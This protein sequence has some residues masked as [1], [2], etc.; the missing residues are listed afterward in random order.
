VKAPRNLNELFFD[1]VDR[2]SSK[3]AAFQY[4][5]DG[6]WHD[7]THQE[8][9]QRV[10][11]TALGLLELGVRSG[12]RVGILSVNRPEW[13]IADYACL[14]VRCVDVPVYPTLPAKQ[15]AYI[16]RDSGAVALFVS[17]PSQYRK[18]EETRAEIPSLK[19][20]I[21]F[22]GTVQGPGVRT[23]QEVQALGASAEG[24]HR[25]YQEEAL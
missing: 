9:L 20:V 23:L 12:D 13:A 5:A 2:F 25:R 17:D 21:L 15:A 16:L 10:R 24:R 18:I 22:D 8:L 1:A 6:A 14:S 11:Q 19:H 3:R 7:V 4:K